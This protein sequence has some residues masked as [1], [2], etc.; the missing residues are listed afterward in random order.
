MRRTST[1]SAAY[2]EGLYRADEDPWRFRTSPYEEAK[3]HRTLEVLGTEGASRALEIGCS[4]GVL[5]EKLADRCAALLATDLSAIALEAARRR[6]EGRAN[7]AFE[8][9]PT[10]LYVPEGRFD[11]IVLSEVLYYFAPTDLER[12]AVKIS[13]AAAPRARL[14]L[15][16]WLGETDYPLAAD[17]AVDRFQAGLE[18]PFAVETAERTPDYRLEVMRRGA[19]RPRRQARPPPAGSG[20]GPAGAGPPRRGT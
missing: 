4:I 18:G 1:L 15:V 9:A 7:V 8:C 20:R 12:L 3:Y 17:E 16:H 14:L 2:F 11:L 13:H 5:T 10:P 19:I 6:C